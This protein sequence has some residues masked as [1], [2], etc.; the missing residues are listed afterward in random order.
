MQ[1]IKEF[2]ESLQ[3]AK[4]GKIEDAFSNTKQIQ[5]G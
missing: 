4:G 1:K 3:L 2:R 5:L